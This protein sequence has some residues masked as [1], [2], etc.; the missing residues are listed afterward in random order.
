LP[1]TRAEIADYLGLTL[2]TVSR[3]LS[4][5]KAK[6]VIALPASRDVVVPDMAVLAAVAHIDHGADALYRH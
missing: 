4:S 6:N 1:F 5:L 2:E 3:Q